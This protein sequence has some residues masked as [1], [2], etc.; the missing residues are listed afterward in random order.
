MTPP[1]PPLPPNSVYRPDIQIDLSKPPPSLHP[2]C[3]QPSPNR[4]WCDYNSRHF[5]F[6]SLFPI[7]HTLQPEW[8]F[9]MQIRWY[10]CPAKAS[11]ALAA[12]E[13]LY[14]LEEG[15]LS[16]IY[17]TLWKQQVKNEG[18]KDWWGY[19]SGGNLKTLWIKST[20][21]YGLKSPARGSPPLSLWPG[22]GLLSLCSLWDGHTG[23]SHKPSCSG[24]RSLAHAL[25]SI[26]ASAWLD[27]P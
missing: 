23:A 18:R 16:F 7:F 20:V 19:W 1:L 24:L 13:F 17:L 21:S 27:P 8:S 11:T 4:D 5:L 6:F 12:S 2:H 25:P 22:I 15:L 3:H 9:K 10:L 14:R 26:S